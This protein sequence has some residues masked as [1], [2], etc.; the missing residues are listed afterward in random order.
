LLKHATK[1][2]QDRWHSLTERTQIEISMIK[3]N[4]SSILVIIAMIL[5]ILNFGYLNFNIDSFSFWLFIGS[6]LLLI[7]ALIKIFITE[8]KEKKKSISD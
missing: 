2:T 1:H 7:A 3:R 8:N 5:N 4:F 6:T